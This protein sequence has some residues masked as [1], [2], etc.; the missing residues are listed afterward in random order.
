MAPALTAPIA[1]GMKISV[2]A[3]FSPRGRSRSA[4]VA[5]SRPRTIVPAGTT[6]IHNN[7]LNNVFW[8]LLEVSS[9]V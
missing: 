8:K 5:M 7:V 6:M 1:R 9:A 3:N 4:K 2:L